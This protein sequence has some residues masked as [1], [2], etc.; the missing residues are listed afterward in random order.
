MPVAERRHFIS[1][2]FTLIELLVVI[3]IIAMLIALLLPALRAARSAARAAAC[4][5]NQRQLTIASLAYLGDHDTTFAQPAEDA[6]LASTYGND[7]AGHV[8]WFNALDSY[9]GI[10]PL[11]YTYHVIVP[12][13]TSFVGRLLLSCCVHE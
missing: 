2:G 9:L 12:P 4:L 8:L 5:S 3:A 1:G 10:E 6:A 13:T 7:Y 11:A